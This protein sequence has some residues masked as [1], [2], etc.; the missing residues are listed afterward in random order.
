MLE[1]VEFPQSKFASDLNLPFPS[2]GLP[3]LK[4]RF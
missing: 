1:R 3:N 4:F 2:F